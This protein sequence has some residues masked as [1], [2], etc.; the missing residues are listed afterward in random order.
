MGNAKEFTMEDIRFTRHR[1]PDI[2]VRNFRFYR[3]I[4]FQTAPSTVVA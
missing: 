1:S 4:F 3:V 2:L